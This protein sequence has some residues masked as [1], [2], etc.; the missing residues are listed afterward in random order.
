MPN[1]ARKQDSA[2]ILHFPPKRVTNV[3][4]GSN[5]DVD[6]AIIEYLFSHPI[7]EGK[8]ESKIKSTFEGLI[9][10]YVIRARESADDEESSFDAV[11]LADLQPDIINPET[12]SE[13]ES[14]SHITDLSESILFEDEVD[15]E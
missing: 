9:D 8:M 7:F 10:D 4:S 3:T 14:F 5:L 12:V 1:L 13:L 11:Y 2:T 15:D 6:D